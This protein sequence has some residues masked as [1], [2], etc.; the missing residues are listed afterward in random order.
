MEIPSVHVQKGKLAIH[1]S[2]AFKMVKNVAVT[3]ADQTLV[4][5]LWAEGLF[6]IACPDLK[7]TLQPFRA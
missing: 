1:L 3:S 4:A 6:A 5:E 7:E 2:D